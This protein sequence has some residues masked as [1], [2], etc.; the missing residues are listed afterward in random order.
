MDANISLEAQIFVLAL[1]REGTF[2]RAAKKL[3]I[4][5]PALTRKIGALEKRLGVKLFNRAYHHLEL[6]PAGRLFLPE[7]QASVQHAE[8]AFELAR[9]RAHLDSGPFRLGYS[10]YVHAELVPMLQR[11]QLQDISSSRGLIL[12]SGSTA[13]IMERVISGTLH[14][15]LGILP[16]VDEQLWVNSVAREQFCVC[17][18]KNHSLAQKASVSAR[19][20]HG[21][22][23]FWVPRAVH[24]GFYD[25]TVEY[26]R[27]LGVQPVFHEVGAGTQAMEIVSHGFGLTLLPRSFTRFSRTGIV[28]KP[29][30]DL[31]LR[32]ETGLFVRETQRHDLLQDHIRLMLSELRGLELNL[33]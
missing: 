21:E 14:A 11:W 9:Q 13:Q 30:T 27:G 33:R 29:L 7:A 31:F 1:A 16:V 24:P 19:D 26:I 3:H 32:I 18:P 8:R 23:I 22:K 15:G 6:T 4:T 12:E 25:Q 5:Q 17:M 28:F 2:S 10:P 20:L